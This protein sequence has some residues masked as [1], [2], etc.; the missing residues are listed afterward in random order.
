MPPERLCLSSVRPA[1]TDFGRRFLIQKLRGDEPAQHGGEIVQQLHR[2][3]AHPGTGV[4]EVERRIAGDEQEV[5]GLGN[6]AL[7]SFGH[8]A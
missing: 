6:A 4:D 8:L 7:S 2:L 1:L 3:A 5:R